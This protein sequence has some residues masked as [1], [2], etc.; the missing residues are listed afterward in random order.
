M[1][2]STPYYLIDEKKLLRNLKIIQQVRRLSGARSVLALKCFSTWS[3]FALMREYMDGTTSS[4]LF[5]A[6]LGF[7]KFGKETHAYCVGYSEEDIRAVTQF[8]DKIIFNSVSQLDRYYDIAKSAKLG[9]RVNPGISYSHFDLAD[10]AR[11][12]SRLGV[13]DKAMLAKQIPRLSGLLFHY[14][15][16]NDD[17][18]AF[19][20][21]LDT[22]G[23]H[24]GDLLEKLQ[25]ISL[26][27]GLYFTKEGYPV[28]KFCQKLAEFAKRFDLQVY[29]EPGESAITGCAELVTRVVDLVQNEIDIAIVDASVEAH[30]LDLLIYRQ[31]AKLD[32]GGRGRYRYMVA[33]RSCLAGDVFGTF[34]FNEKLEIGSE[35]RFADAA[36]YTMVKKNWFNGLKMPAIVVRR[37]NGTE[38]LV[39]EFDYTDFINCLS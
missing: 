31:A 17:F 14:N 15:C 36:G 10:P 35:I 11:S 19:S 37:L 4:S 21:Q 18:D 28:E 16:E 34:Q 6:R 3:V 29:L 24:Y 23:E 26:G 32:T 20:R 5:E 33:G 27:G 39:K 12:Y 25:W 13:V 8:A 38:E 9:L 2:I 22:I 1:K 30:M 7:E